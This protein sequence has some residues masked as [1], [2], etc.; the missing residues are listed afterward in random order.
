[1]TE[2]LLLTGTSHVT[3]DSNGAAR[4]TD[5]HLDIKLS[6]PHLAAE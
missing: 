1:M 2:R 5:G 3:G 6:A 4:N